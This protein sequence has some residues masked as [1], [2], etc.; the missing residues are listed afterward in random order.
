MKSMTR[1]LETVAAQSGIPMRNAQLEHSSRGSLTASRIMV[2]DD[3][4]LNINVVCAHLGCEGYTQFVKVSDSTQAMTTL[5]REDPDLLLLDMMMPGVSGLDILQVLRADQHFAHLPVLILTASDDRKMKKT[6]L[7]AGAT[8]FLLKPID[9]DDLIPR[10]RNA[11]LMKRH[12]DTLE[13]QVRERTLELE[14]SRVEVVHCLA[15]AAEQRDEDTGNHVVRVGQYVGIISRELGYDEETARL[16]ELASILHDVG[17]IGIP[18]S[19]LLKPGKLTDEEF[20][21]MKTHSKIGESIC[22]PVAADESRTTSAHVLRNS[23]S[24]L[25]KIAASIAATHHEKWDGSGYPRGLAGD[26]IPMEGRIAAV[27]DVFDAL[28]SKRPY[29][30]AFTVEKCFA[31]LKEGSGV[32]FDPQVVDAFFARQEDVV[33]VRAIYSDE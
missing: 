25:L 10:V 32:H 21:V 30:S 33:N 11:L 12:R 17:K 8:D 16:F 26:A 28:S 3:V 9:A 23:K 13:Q 24:P 18:D 4:P 6:A 31:I 29:K 14:E 2:V 5:Y 15:R 20:E 1:S 19:I 22:S 7:D 27:A